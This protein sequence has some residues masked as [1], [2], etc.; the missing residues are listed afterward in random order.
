MVGLYMYALTAF[1]FL[2]AACAN[3]GVPSREAVGS[4]PPIEYVHSKDS[5]RYVRKLDH[6]CDFVGNDIGG[7][8]LGC[9]VLFLISLA[10]FS[11]YLLAC[12]VVYT[13]L[14]YSP[15]R[16]AL[17]LAPL[18][19]WWALA[20]LLMAAV[21]SALIKCSREDCC[22]GVLPLIMM[23]PGAR[24]GMT[25]LAI[26]CVAVVVLPCITNLWSDVSLERNPSAFFFILPLLAFSVRVPPPHLR[27]LTQCHVEDW[28]SWWQ[29]LFC[30]M[31]AHWIWLLSDGLSQR[32]WL[33]AK[34]WGRFGF[35]KSSDPQGT[36][37][38]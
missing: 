35:K 30:G 2:L 9:F 10:V 3:P 26:V 20:L 29:V 19:L 37:M 28:R 15:P 6:F 24:C 16:P 17:Q 13:A 8:N 27:P 11:T 32:L 23:M 12:C 22:D 7:D 38:M 4:P 36:A 34:G 33:K 31:S 25:A 5:S 18:S 21:V 14:M 1:F